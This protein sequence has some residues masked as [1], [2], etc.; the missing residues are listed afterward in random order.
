M[1]TLRLS[2]LRNFDE[3]ETLRPFT[4]DVPQC[5][6]VG[7]QLFFDE[8]GDY[9]YAVKRVVWDMSEG[10]RAAYVVLDTRG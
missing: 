10:G 2:F 9:E 7:D 4:I 6:R 8:D 5:P 3:H 1:I